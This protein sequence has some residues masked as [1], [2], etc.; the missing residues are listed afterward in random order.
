MRLMVTS[1]IIPLIFLSV[2]I[3]LN[4]MLLNDSKT[5]KFQYDAFFI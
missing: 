3:L 5:L 4:I 1:E 2:V